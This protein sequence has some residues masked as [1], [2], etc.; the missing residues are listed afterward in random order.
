[1]KGARI[2][3]TALLPDIMALAPSALPKLVAQ[4]N[5]LARDDGA[6]QS[7][8]VQPRAAVRGGGP[9]SGATAVIPVVGVILPRSNWLSDFLGWSTAAGIKQAVE[10]AA[11]DNSIDQL[12]LLVDSPG[13]DVV[14]IQEAADAIFETRDEEAEQIGRQSVMKAT[15]RLIDQR[16]G[17]ESC[18]PRIGAEDVVDRAS[19]CFG[20]G[21]RDRT[22]M[23][24]AVGEA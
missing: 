22:T 8:A 23:K 20:A 10:A 17:G 12:L 24:L 19:E 2:D 9:R 7:G 15:P 16:K 13:G 11:A 6:A 1:M 21:A 5:L 14:G 18:D 3:L 4:I